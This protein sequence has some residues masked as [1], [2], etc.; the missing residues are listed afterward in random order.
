MFRSDCFDEDTR[1]RRCIEEF[2][3][4]LDQLNRE[5]CEKLDSHLNSAVE[6]SIAGI[7][8]FRV[9]H[10]GPRIEKVTDKDPL[11]PR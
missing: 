10:D 8:Y 3:N 5:V 1:L 11:V 9:Q 2:K 6:N 4:K 7:R